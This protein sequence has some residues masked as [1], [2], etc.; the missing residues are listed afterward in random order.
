MRLFTSWKRCTRLDVARLLFEV[1]LQKPLIE[2]ITFQD[3][4]ETRVKVGVSYP[5]LPPQYL[6]CRKRGHKVNGCREQHVNLFGKK[7]N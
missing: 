4:D 2:G 5:W 1:N 3:K 7:Q 6:L